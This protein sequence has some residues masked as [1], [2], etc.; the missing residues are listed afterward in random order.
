MRYSS[1]FPE[2]FG[3]EDPQTFLYEPAR[4]DG[5]FIHW[6]PLNNYQKLRLAYDQA[7]DFLLKVIQACD[8]F[9]ADTGMKHG[10]L[11]TEATDSARTFLKRMETK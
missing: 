11:I 5:P 6:V 8:R 2:G 1:R 3:P 4:K 7:T 9:T 10:D